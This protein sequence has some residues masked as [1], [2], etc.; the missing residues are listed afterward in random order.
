MNEPSNPNASAGNG[1]GNGKLN[2]WARPD[3]VVSS[4]VEDYVAI[5]AELLDLK[6]DVLALATVTGA[7]AINRGSR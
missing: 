1:M 2:N 6:K 5:W 3:D 7:L 4:T